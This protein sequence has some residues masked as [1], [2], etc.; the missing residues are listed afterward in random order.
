MQRLEYK[1]FSISLTFSAGKFTPE[2]I[3]EHDVEVFLNQKVKEGWE[4]K[5]EIERTIGTVRG[6]YKGLF[7]KKVC[8]KWVPAPA[9]NDDP[10]LSNNPPRSA[11]VGHTL[12]E[13]IER[14][15]PKPLPWGQCHCQCHS[16]PN[17]EHCMP[18]C[19]EC[20]DCGLNITGDLESHRKETHSSDDDPC[21]AAEN[22]V[23]S[24]TA[25]AMDDQACAPP[26]SHQTRTVAE[27][28]EPGLKFL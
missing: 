12:I 19:V 8:E 4:L 11:S 9:V 1:H 25:L 10:D 21:P 3:F 20:P 16:N 5:T 28:E 22:K 2:E 15:L 6:F 18:C 14:N 23:I 26:A 27:T 24:P 17:V 7:V 13:E